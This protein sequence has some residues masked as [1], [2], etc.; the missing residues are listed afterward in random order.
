MRQ[1][2]QELV[3]SWFKATEND[4][5]KLLRRLDTEGVPETSQLMLDNLFSVLSKSEFSAMVQAWA[6]NYL[7]EEYVCIF[8]VVSFIHGCEIYSKVLM[9]MTL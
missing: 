3:I 4:P 9:L 1:A 5:V 8:A 7:N 6:T 2:A